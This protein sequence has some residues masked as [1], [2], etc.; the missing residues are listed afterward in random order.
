M[1][2]N[3]LV[4]AEDYRLDQYVLKPLVEKML[5]GVGQPRARV[6]MCR[7]PFFT[8]V[9]H[10]LQTESLREIVETNRLA[11]L[12]L[13][14]VDRD[15]KEGRE[16]RIADREAEVQALIGDRKAFVG[17]LA[18][19]EVEVWLLGGHDTPDM[20]WADVRA[21]EHPKEDFFEPFAESKGVHLGPGKGRSALAK[22]M[23]TRYGRLCQRC[24]E[25]KA[26]E[27]RIR[28][29]LAARG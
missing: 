21:S 18:W 11:D 4:I 14:I 16:A 26:L 1:S 10:V 12:Y 25:V 28:A 13:L 23:V 9:D 22:E 15:G 5:A 27:D 24:P 7:D 3:V 19:Q 20:T 6:E 2:L 8:G 17:A 29:W